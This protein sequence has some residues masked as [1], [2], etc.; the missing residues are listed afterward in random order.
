[1]RKRLTR[2]PFATTP[3]APSVPSTRG[4]RDRPAGRHEPSRIDSSQLP[5]P[6]A[7]TAITI[8]RGPGCGTGS[9][10]T[11]MTEGGPKRSIAAALIEAW[12]TGRAVMRLQDLQDLFVARAI[13]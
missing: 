3:P 2:A 4:N 6:A 1:M 12:K 5:T 7:W 13:V 8:W 11:V 10:W 9:V